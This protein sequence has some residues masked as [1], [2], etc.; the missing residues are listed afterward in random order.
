MIPV[1]NCDAAL[2][3][4]TERI[5]PILAENCDGFEM[6]LVDDGS[7]TN[8]WQIIEQLAES[9]DWIRG[10]QLMRNYGQ[11]NAPPKGADLPAPTST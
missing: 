9:H 11:H 5:E 3:T 4:L 2:P 10:V 6:I 8:A 7:R 1:Y